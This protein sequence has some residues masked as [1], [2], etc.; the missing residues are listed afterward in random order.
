MGASL[1][2]LC[3]PSDFGGRAGS[4]V[5]MGCVFSWGMLVAAALVGVGLE[6]ERLEPEPCVG[7]SFSPGAIVVSTLLESGAGD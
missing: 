5:S 6:L 1:C 3:V 2:S 4:K 7:W